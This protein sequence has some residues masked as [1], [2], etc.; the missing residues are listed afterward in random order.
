[1]VD[2]TQLD[3]IHELFPI[4]CESYETTGFADGVI[5][6]FKTFYLKIY[7]DE[8]ENAYIVY[9]YRFNETQPVFIYRVQWKDF[10]TFANRF[11][12]E[13]Y[14]KCFGRMCRSCESWCSDDA[15]SSK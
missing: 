8:H 9:G 6:R 15:P 3:S 4:P 1:M 12:K 13:D 2:Y 11:T 5:I 10:K 7:D 14:L